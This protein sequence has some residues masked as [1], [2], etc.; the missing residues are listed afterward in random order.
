[1]SLVRS[2]LGCFNDNIRDSWYDLLIFQVLVSEVTDEAKI[3]ACN[4]NDGP[5]LE[6]LMDCLREEFTANPP[7]IYQAIMVSLYSKL[8]QFYTETNCDDFI[9]LWNEMCRQNAH[10]DLRNLNIFRGRRGWVKSISVSAQY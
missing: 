6:K 9:P 8:C 5:A 7:V 1:M 3:Y 4:V 2:K 10:Q